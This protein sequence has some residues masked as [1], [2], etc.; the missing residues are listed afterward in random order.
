VKRRLKFPRGYDEE[1]TGGES[2]RGVL[3]EVDNQEELA[4]LA[5]EVRCRRGIPILGAEWVLKLV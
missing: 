4:R 3:M 5:D 1:S 2:E